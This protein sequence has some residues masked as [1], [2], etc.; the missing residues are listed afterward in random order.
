MKIEKIAKDRKWDAPEVY[1]ANMEDND[2]E[3]DM[4]LDPSMNMAVWMQKMDKIAARLGRIEV[5]KEDDAVF[6]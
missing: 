1:F 6:N 5:Q 3:Q 4:Q 2:V